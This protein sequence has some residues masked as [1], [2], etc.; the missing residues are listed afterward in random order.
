MFPFQL[1]CIYLK[2]VYKIIIIQISVNYKEGIHFKYV[3]KLLE[4]VGDCE[5]VIFII[6]FNYII[7]KFRYMRK[8][9]NSKKCLTNQ[10]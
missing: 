1:I 4:L 3:D 6:Y 2:I 8:N 9:V 5:D 7:L 10:D